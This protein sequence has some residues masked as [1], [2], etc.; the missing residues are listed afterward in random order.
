MNLIIN[1]FNIKRNYNLFDLIS[2]VNKLTKTAVEEINQ[3]S[4]HQNKILCL[5]TSVYI[6][7]VV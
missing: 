5:Y 6:H 7:T 3:P 2:S 4:A 1:I